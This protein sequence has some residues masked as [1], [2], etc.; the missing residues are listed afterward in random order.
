MNPFAEAALFGATPLAVAVAVLAGLV[1]FASPCVLPL[2]PGYLGYVTGLT[3]VGLE[4]LRRRRMVGGTGLFVLGFTVVF[5]LL[6]TSLSQLSQDVLRTHQATLTRVLGVVVIALGLLFVGWLPGGGK[7]VQTTWRPAAG[8]AGA[9]LLGGVFALGWTPCLG[10]TLA[11]VLSLATSD[12]GGAGRGLTLALA[13]SLGLGLP[14]MLVALG[15]ARASVVLS[16]LSRHQRGLQVAGAS[17][18]VLLGV[19]MVSGVWDR[20]MT[21]VGARIAGFVVPV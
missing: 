3:G 6:F 19:L 13:Y 17:L 5:V 10:P 16:V 12:G 2:V 21:T 11:A 14:F 18:L 4:R 8:L 7:V 15:Y 20:L 1:S 9:P